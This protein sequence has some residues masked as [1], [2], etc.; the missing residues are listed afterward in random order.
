[1]GLRRRSR[2][3]QRSQGGAWCVRFRQGRPHFEAC[4]HA[5]EELGAGAA[6][7]KSVVLVRT[8]GGGDGEPIAD[9]DEALFDLVRRAVADWLARQE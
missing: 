1:M 5:A 4:G 9:S 8:S 6:F 2:S 3:V 7:F